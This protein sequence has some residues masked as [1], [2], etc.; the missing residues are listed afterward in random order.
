MN[1]G[2][3][4]ICEQLGKASAD[5]LPVGVA[6]DERA[7][8]ALEPPSHIEHLVLSLRDRW[9]TALRG[10][11]PRHMVPAMLDA[12]AAAFKARMIAKTS[13][14]AQEMRGLDPLKIV[15]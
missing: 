7:V 12:T 3:Q 14:V 15:V 10:R 5:L 6:I 1:R 11:F 4:A 9:E 13:P 8:G 2:L